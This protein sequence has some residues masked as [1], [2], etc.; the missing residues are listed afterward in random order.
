MFLNDGKFE[1]GKNKKDWFFV[2]A[3]YLCCMYT[4]STIS[5]NYYIMQP[6]KMADLI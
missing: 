5:R 6:N 3:Y 1:T 4:G 2:L